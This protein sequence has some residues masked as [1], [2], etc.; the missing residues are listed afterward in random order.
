[1]CPDQN[2]AGQLTVCKENIWQYIAFFVVT[3]FFCARQIFGGS[4]KEKKK[5]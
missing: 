3:N 1:M 4:T 2:K 5:K